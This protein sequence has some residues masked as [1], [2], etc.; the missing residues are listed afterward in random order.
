MPRGIDGE[1]L[2]NRARTMRPGLPVLLTSG[3]AAVQ[4]G[5]D[6]SSPHF[7]MLRKP[8]RSDDLARAVAHAIASTPRAEPAAPGAAGHAGP[9]V[10]VVEDDPLVLMSTA[11]M[12]AE[13]GF[14]VA[15]EAETAEA[16]LA[17]LEQL[18]DIAVVFS[19]VGLPGMSGQDLADQIRARRP[20]VCVVLTT[21]YAPPGVTRSG[22]ALMLG[23]PF[24]LG[25]LARLK[26]ELAAAD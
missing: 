15:G 6:R 5:E 1:D 11:D 16:A 12:L 9:K 26:S 2:A 21:G 13:A 25:D 7:P 14:D 4:R 10:L 24:M 20:D 22:T 17:M 19:D 8:Y 3:Y 23:K 18:P